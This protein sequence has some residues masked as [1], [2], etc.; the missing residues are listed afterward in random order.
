V[1]IMAAAVMVET[2]SLSRF[3]VDGRAVLFK[4]RR[5]EWEKVKYFEMGRTGRIGW[6]A[7]ATR[8]SRLAGPR[9]HRVGHARPHRGI[10]HP[11]AGNHQ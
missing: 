10:L 3:R 2:R 4:M 8:L 11:Q 7:V 1:K 9:V 6:S 5:V